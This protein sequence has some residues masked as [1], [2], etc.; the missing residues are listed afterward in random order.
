MNHVLC[1]CDHV[2]IVMRVLVV[3]SIICSSGPARSSMLIELCSV[4]ILQL[5]SQIVLGKDLQG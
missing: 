2:L 1:E 4:M 3:S 5:D